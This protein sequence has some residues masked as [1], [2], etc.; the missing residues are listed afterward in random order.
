MKNKVELQLAYEWICD[1]CGRSNFESAMQ[2]EM[3]DMDRELIAEDE[4]VDPNEVGGTMMEYPEIVTC[5][6]C[7]EDFETDDEDMIL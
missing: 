2:A 3:T 4:G 5:K 6:H 7:G 1:A